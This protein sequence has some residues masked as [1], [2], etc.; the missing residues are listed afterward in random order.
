MT[1]D[2]RPTSSSSGGGGGAGTAVFAAWCRHRGNFRRDNE[3]TVL[4]ESL[5][6]PGGPAAAAGA[7]PSDV[8][9]AVLGADGR[10]YLALVCDGVGG[11]AAG[12]IAS[13]LAARAFAGAMQK[14]VPAGALELA[15]ASAEQRTAWMR[16][17]VAEANA[18]IL[19][20]VERDRAT[21][22]M[23]TTLTAVWGLGGEVHHAQVGD[24]RLYRLRAS[25]LEQLSDDQ[26]LVGR[27][28]R[29]GDL[30]EAQAR[31]HP[32]RNI[33]D[34][35]VGS[36]AGAKADVR[37]FPVEQGDMFLICSDGL[38]D[39]LPDSVI[40]RQLVAG[41]RTAPDAVVA[42][43]LGTV[44]DTAGRDNVSIVLLRTGTERSS[45]ASSLLA[46]AK[47]ARRRRRAAARQ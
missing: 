3:D 35:V 1:A 7:A 12:E 36:E 18:G 15:A 10:G 31:R 39:S 46:R 6:G 21:E 5:D 13:A 23:G 24:S 38:T 25:R 20:A 16:E 17:A 47:L 45:L 30:D 22:G 29:A 42:G 34:Q 4:V 33:V 8:G 19:A 2:G 37:V 40:E 28:R 9:T 11:G 44:L 26:S 14:R 32:L 41:L 43:L 27:M